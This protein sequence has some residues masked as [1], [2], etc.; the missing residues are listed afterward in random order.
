MSAWVSFS[1]E[2]ITLNCQPIS[3]LCRDLCPGVRFAQNIFDLLEVKR[4]KWISV[5]IY[6][7]SK[8]SNSYTVWMFQKCP[9]YHIRYIYQSS[10]Q[11]FW[12]S[13]YEKTGMISFSS[14]NMFDQQYF[15]SCLLFI[16]FLLQ[17]QGNV[18]FILH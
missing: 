5:T 7:Y 2:D 10:H 15:L 11:S 17:F 9:F 4:K 13:C 8:I 3:M 12:S 18:N 14:Y 16:N 6:F 1:L